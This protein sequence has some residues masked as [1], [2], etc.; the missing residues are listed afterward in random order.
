MKKRIIAILVCM[1]FFMSTGVLADPKLPEELLNQ[2]MNFTSLYNISFSITDTSDLRGLL[3]E[4]AEENYFY[5]FGDMINSNQMI[6]VLT[7]LYD[8][9][10]ILKVEADISEDF[11]K[12][13][14]SLVSEDSL[15][16]VV[17]ANLNYTVNIKWGLWADIDL[18]NPEAYKMD[19]ILRL[20][21]ED[22]YYYF[23]AGQYLDSETVEEVYSAID[24]KL[25]DEIKNDIDKHIADFIAIEKTEK[26]FKTV[27]SNKNLIDYINYAIAYHNESISDAETVIVPDTL[28]MLGDA[29]I[30]SEY[31]IQDG[32]VAHETSTAEFSLDIANIYTSF[33][34]DEWT[35]TNTGKINFAITVYADFMK[36]GSTEVSFPWIT[37][38]NGICLNSMI[39]Q[40]IYPDSVDDY[41]DEYVPDYPNYYVS[42]DW[43]GFITAT[44]EFY[45]PLRNILEMAYDDTVIIG[46]NNG[47]I[48]I[49]CD[50]FDNFKSLGM[51]VGY[52]Q[53]CVDGIERYIGEVMLVDGVVYV[54][55]KLFTEIFGWKLG[56]AMSD[57]MDNTYDFTFYTRDF[58]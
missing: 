52:D 33:T 41:Y 17:S 8:Y 2:P 53:V 27:I 18:S 43:D 25:F 57:L 37:E 44:G 29:G 56:S 46:Y 13:K 22:K 21:D 11:R 14:V 16:S 39:E 34:G 32:M 19:V 4:F 5:S 38:T 54:N 10:G 58:Y 42:T 20:P 12:M 30:Q 31:I 51:T 15:K 48:T 26:G 3:Q 6:N 24:L 55:T 36:Y 40:E 35:Y 7:A 47:A 49:Y 28:K 45:V 1:M 50:H 9:K 23:N